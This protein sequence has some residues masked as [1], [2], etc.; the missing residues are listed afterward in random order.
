M[1]EL[2]YEQRMRLKFNH[3]ASITAFKRLEKAIE[4]SNDHEIYSAIGELLLWVMT[5]HEWH[6]KH[7]LADYYNRAGQDEK[8]LLLFGLAHAYNSMK[9]NMKLFVIHN[10]IGLHFNNI[11][12][13]KIDFRP[14]AVRWIKAANL[15]DE[16]FPN[17]QKNYV[18]YIEDKDVLKT[19]NDVLIFLNNEMQTLIFQKE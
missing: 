12:F 9:H 19:F 5:T 13:N 15:L 1:S 4:E 18:D 7:G 16:G 11:D 10:K 8:G 6:K 3:Y 2:N 14:Y 17:Q